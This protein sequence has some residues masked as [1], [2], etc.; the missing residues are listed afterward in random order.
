M[1][2]DRN[3]ETEQRWREEAFSLVR[4]IKQ[5]TE[6]HREVGRGFHGIGQHLAPGLLSTRPKPQ[7][8]SLEPATPVLGQPPELPSGDVRS[9]SLSQALLRETPPILSVTFCLCSAK[10]CAPHSGLTG[11]V[12]RNSH[13]PQAISTQ[14]RLIKVINV[15][16]SPNERWHQLWLTGWKAPA[17]GVGKAMGG[18]RWQA[19]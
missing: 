10:P 11:R 8:L 4:A 7:D 17:A 2:S 3:R 13:P 6:E 1:T 9:R 16:L 19:G 18:G 5:V 15:K 12:I 14:C